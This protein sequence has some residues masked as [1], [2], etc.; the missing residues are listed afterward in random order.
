MKPLN[1]L[2][3]AAFITVGGILANTT[4]LFANDLPQEFTPF[5]EMGFG[6]NSA[7][8]DRSMPGF[9]FAAGSSPSYVANLGAGINVADF[10]DQIAVSLGLILQQQNLRVERIESL[11]GGGSLSADGSNNSTSVIVRGTASGSL[12]GTESLGWRAGVGAGVSSQVF[13]AR[14]LNSIVF[15][16]NAITP[17]LMLHGGLTNQFDDVTTGFIDV[18]A[19]WMPGFTVS[20]QTGLTSTLADQWRFAVVIGAQR[21]FGQ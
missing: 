16:G 8:S 10:N 18:Q 17:T 7:S 13:E 11:T 3:C 20:S 14:H 19:N 12:S 4:A 5:V 1:S 2:A 9:N 6:L 15:S 21:S